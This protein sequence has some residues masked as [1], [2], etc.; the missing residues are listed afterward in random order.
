MYERFKA[1][2]LPL[3]TIIVVLLA[4]GGSETSSPNQSK[5]ET[6]SPNQ[7]KEWYVGGTLHD[8]TIAEW[9]TASYDNRLATCADFVMTLGKYQSLPPDLKTR[10]VD[11][12]ACISKAV[13]DGNVDY[14]SV[15]EIGGTCGVLL[16]Y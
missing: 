10:A 8:K 15:S 9:R 14:K 5:E 13:E 6:S 2:A 7:S 16:G 12:E 3:I 11:L 4:C 1:L